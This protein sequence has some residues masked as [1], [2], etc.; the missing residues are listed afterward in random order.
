[1]EKT[2]SA[3]LETPPDTSDGIENPSEEEILALSKEPDPDSET[4]NQQLSKEDTYKLVRQYQEEKSEDALV[5]L[6]TAYDGFCKKKADYFAKKTGIDVDDLHQEARIGLIEG[7]KRFQTS[8]KNSVLTYAGWWIYKYVQKYAA[9]QKT[10]QTNPAKLSLSSQNILNSYDTLMKE[11]KDNNPHKSPSDAEDTIEEKLGVPIS[12][13]KK[14]LTMH[15]TG[16]LSLD[17]PFSK[18][19]A[20]GPTHLDMLETNTPDVFAAAAKTS[21][22][23]YLNRLLDA[24]E[25][26]DK[27]RGAI[28]K[29]YLEPN[30]EEIRTLAEVGEMMNVTSE[31]ISSFEKQ[32]LKKMLKKAETSTDPAIAVPECI[33]RRKARS[34]SAR[35]SKVVT[36][37]SN[38]SITFLAD[39]RAYTSTYTRENVREAMELYIKNNP[40][41]IEPRVL[42]GVIKGPCALANDKRAWNSVYQAFDASRVEGVPEGTTMGEFAHEEF[43]TELK[44][45]KK[46]LSLASTFNS[47]AWHILKEQA[48]PPANDTPINHGH[49]SQQT[50][51][52][53][54]YKDATVT[55]L[56]NKFSQNSKRSYGDLDKLMQAGMVNNIPKDMTLLTFAEHVETRLKAKNFKAP[57]REEV[58]K[59]D[60]AA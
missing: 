3:T 7:I 51:L 54:E 14:I 21:Y 26:T 59:W 34:S 56:T 36:P 43:G 16:T 23:C 39:K 38:D 29:R 27:Q 44:S 2:T 6:L 28:K 45:P 31:S 53:S 52:L 15:Y 8:S 47:V 49:L 55:A 18:N 10:T 13:V 48:L 60:L 40:D 30:A 12:H 32:A 17:A 4:S 50:L 33:N 5:K 37:K 24:T 42:S 25:L 20:Y 22:A 46:T 19:N 58:L 57:T 1:M 11:Y 9:E 35:K 41:G